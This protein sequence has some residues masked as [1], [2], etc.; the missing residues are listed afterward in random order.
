MAN[1]LLP[2]RLG[3]FVRAYALATKEEV[4]TATV[5]ATL[6][7]DRLCDGFTILLVLVFTFFIIR[8]PAG[9]E[10][11]QKAMVTGGYVMLALYLAV[12][13][14]LAVLSWQTQR[15]LAVVQALLSPLPERFG[16]KVCGALASFIGGI[17]F[18][19]APAQILGVALSSFLIWATAIWPVDIML[20][21]FG[22][23]LPITAS[24]FIMV[25]L[26]FAVMVPA[27]PGYLGTYHFACVTALSA[28]GIK[29]ERALS[30]ALVVHGV[31][32]F[33]VVVAGLAVLWREKM[34]LKNL[35]GS[36]REA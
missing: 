15:T 14:F 7:L 22:I 2:A 34:S 8:L 21:A 18:P 31:G 5:F 35:T 1:N 24:M 6:V 29:S 33:P 36:D 28:F 10:H 32:F 30:I 25:F 17:R 26:V 20:R 11:V 3:E 16:E 27:S 4:P 19:K 23:A 13:A 12:L 9:M